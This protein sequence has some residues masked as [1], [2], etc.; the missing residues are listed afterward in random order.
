MI[1]RAL[2]SVLY[3]AVLSL[4]FSCA[5]TTTPPMGGPKDTIPPVLLKITPDSGRVNFPLKGGTIELRFDEYVVLKEPQKNVFLSP[6]TFLKPELK[7][8]GKSIIVNLPEQLDS[9]TTYTINFGNAIVDNNE[10]NLFEP[11]VFPFSTGTY[12]DSIMCTGTIV[13]Y[14]TLLPEA[15]VTIAFYKDDCDS[16]IYNSLPSAMARSDKFGFFLIRNVAERPYRVFAF[17]DINNNYKYEPDYELVAFM[18]TLFTPVRVLNRDLPELKYVDEKDTLAAMGRPSELSMYLFREDPEKFFIR[19]CK[20]LQHN[21]AFV[22]FS[23]PGAEVLSV[24]FKEIDSISVLKEFNIRR[25]SLVIWIKDTTLVVPDTLNLFV[26]YLK[27][28]SLN[29]LTPATEDFRLIHKRPVRDYRRESRERQQEEKETKRANLLEFEIAADPALIETNGFRLNFTA[30][31]A[32]I[33]YDSVRIESK[34]PRGE[35]TNIKYRLEKDSVFSRIISVKPEEKMLQGYEYAL[36]IH[37]GAFKDIYKNTNDSS[38]TKV[39]LP[40]GDQLS[41]L[42]LDISGVDGSYIVDLTNITRDRVFRSYKITGDALLEFPY[43]QPGKFS[44]RITQDLNGNGIIDTGSISQ[45]RQP[46]KVRLYTLPDGSA[47]IS[48]PE[49]AEVTQIIKITDIFN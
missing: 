37:K 15:D 30:P 25:D 8:R 24:K 42:F 6:P 44:V 33:N 4:I 18:D 1:L 2:R 26:T 39:S 48:I 23:A 17:K 31:L 47:I 10:G 14:Q 7:I 22:K 49:S 32:H 27:T 3:L 29:N 5:N 41:K 19:D 11:Y 36:V 16:A 46:E 45:K 38:Y 43:L 40:K 9:A 21:M 13:N 34:S 20:R 12:V 35:T 28:D